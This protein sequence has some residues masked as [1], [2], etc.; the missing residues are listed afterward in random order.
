MLFSQKLT[1]AQSGFE[2]LNDIALK[3]QNLLVL[4]FFKHLTSSEY[5][6]D[7]FRYFFENS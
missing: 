6:I 1:T 4:D 7:N 3:I 2:F 5:Y